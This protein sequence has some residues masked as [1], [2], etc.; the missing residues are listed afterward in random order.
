MLAETSTGPAEHSAR[1]TLLWGALILAAGLA[2]VG[3]G[4]AEVGAIPVM[5]GLFLT[6]FGIHTYGRLGPEDGADTGEIDERARAAAHGAIWQG[7]LTVLGGL[8]V[9]LSTYYAAESRGGA[10]VVAWGAMLAG[11]GRAW[12]GV[13]ALRGRKPK[14]KARGRVE[15]KR[16]MDKS[17]AP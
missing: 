9:T 12:M 14:A 15:K 13:H 6:I 5:A 1:T 3:V 11:A 4:S 17:P 10:Y 2:L 7:G 16:R 8:V